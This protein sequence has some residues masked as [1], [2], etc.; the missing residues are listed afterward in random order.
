MDRGAW[1]VT[2]H[3]VAKSGTQLSDYAH[4][5]HTDE[6]ICR[7]AVEMQTYS[8]DLWTQGVGEG[9]GGING[10]AWKHIHWHT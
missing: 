4:A 2:V 6:P 9:E 3:G 5:K 10:V 7:A 8:T 1:R